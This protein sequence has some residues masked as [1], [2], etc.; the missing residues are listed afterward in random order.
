MFDLTVNEMTPAEIRF[1]NNFK[2]DRYLFRVFN[3]KRINGCAANGILRDDDGIPYAVSC[4]CGHHSYHPV[5][6]DGKKVLWEPEFLIKEKNK[7]LVKK[8]IR[9]LW[10]RQ[11]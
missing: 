9:D 3:S 7:S 5:A 6:E 4:N 11:L 8:R 2:Y 1:L 10:I